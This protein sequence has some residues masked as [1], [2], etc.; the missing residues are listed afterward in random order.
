MQ[1]VVRHQLHKFGGSSLANVECIKGV[2]SIIQNYSKENDVIVVS[3]I[4]K[5]TN[6]LIEWVEASHKDTVAANRICK[7]FVIS[8]W[9][10]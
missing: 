10:W 8:I 4:G 5:T 7:I 2:A 3:A 9:Q 6:L 1:Q